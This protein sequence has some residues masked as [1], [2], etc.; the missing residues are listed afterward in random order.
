M[1]DQRF[2]DT[3]TLTNQLLGVP[4]NHRDG[5][6]AAH[7]HDLSLDIVAALKEYGDRLLYSDPIAAADATACA[8]LVAR[9][10][11]DQPLALPLAQ[12]ARGNWE[13]YNDPQLAVQLYQ[14]A[15][16]GYRTTSDR[17]SIARLLSNLVFAYCDCGR[18]D[19]A[20]AAYREARSI[21]LPLGEAT[22]YYLLTL[23]QNYAVLIDNAGQYDQALEAYE[24]ALQ[25]A[26]QLDQPIIAAEIQVNRTIALEMTG[27]LAEQEQA[28]LQ[29]RA[30]AETHDQALTIARIDLNLGEL[31][32]AQ[33]RPVEAL[34][35]LQ[36]ARA[37]FTA[38][39]NRMEVGTVLLGEAALFKRMGALGQARE[40]YAR[41]QAQFTDLQ[42]L[43]QVGI[44]LIHCAAA[45]RLDGAYTDAA[46]L[47]DEAEA[48]WQALDQPHWQAAVTFERAE[49]ALMQNNVGAATT[50]LQSLSVADNLAL[51]ARRDLLLAD[52]R[53]LAWQIDRTPAAK[54]DA[55]HGYELALAYA[56]QHSDRWMQWCAQAGLGRL[57]LS[58]APDAARTQLEAAAAYDDLV[59]Q[60]LSM[61]ELK[62]AV[63]LDTGQVL[64][65]LAR[66]SA[67]QAQPLRA[68]TYI[69]RAKG[70]ALLELV[71]ATD[72]DQAR[73]PADQAELAQLRQKMAV[74][75]WRVAR[76][77]EIAFEDAH[78]YSDETMLSLEQQI[79]TLQQQHVL[80]N[81]AGMLDDPMPLLK[82]MDAD[83]L[84]E[85]IV[86]DKDLLAV[87]ADRNGAC[88]TA[89]L[90][91][92]DTLCTLQDQLYLSFER[93]LA[94]PDD[95]T[96]VARTSLEDCRS[97]LHRCYELLIAP[98]GSI[99]DGAR[100]L[101]A[102]CA[103][104]YGLP[105][106]AL[107][108][109]QQYLI[110]RCEV[111]ASPC[112]ALLAIPPRMAQPSAPLIVAVSRDKR[113]NTGY[114]EVERIKEILPDAVGLVD[115]SQTIELLSNLP[116][117]PRILHIDAPYTSQDNAPIFS[118]LQLP[119][120]QLSV[121]QCYT[122]ALSG[123]DLVTLSSCIS[124]G[125]HN[126][127]GALLAF[128]CAFFAAGARF[129]LSNVW[130]TDREA[131]ATWLLSFYQ[132][133]ANGDPPPTAARK[134]QQ[135]L[136]SVA[137]ARHPAVWAAFT[138]ARR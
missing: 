15:L 18:F 52:A 105:F 43:P 64:P 89:W 99:P 26:Y 96:S 5:W 132:F 47:L 116:I 70:S 117:P 36:A 76:D 55:R 41:A 129:V 107:W 22:A 93:V 17:L 91:E 125:A 3:Q 21:L 124:A 94:A 56:E 10:L 100:L 86:C 103:A 66:L 127:G 114:I 97:L 48:L 120:Q 121:E 84:I 104:L 88:Q 79:H 118:A 25:L 35:R 20:L 13:A 8:L 53:S 67:E 33:G 59:R 90:A 83:I 133:L 112:G 123:A 92:I 130:Q 49:L 7:Q 75:R 62:A 72:R 82:Q 106:A 28:L 51:T 44:A 6:L 136:M 24:R 63:L 42:M 23:E 50:L 30:V 128:Q 27:R 113:L 19:E 40:R 74:Q 57:E 61:D 115:N 39:G 2:P 109:G 134:T 122:L 14:Q 137:A 98:L 73:A 108:D 71:W 12:W 54:Q 101:L 77:A 46:R 9:Y 78:E 81:T 37:Q 38:L 95:R 102:P 110:E 119:G 126:I 85:Y 45:S 87:R 4:A 29:A 1:S 131:A 65:L 32:S 16:I 111:Q 31:Y 34:D 69:W 138:L 11:P 135:A 80:P 68:L 60:A 58:D